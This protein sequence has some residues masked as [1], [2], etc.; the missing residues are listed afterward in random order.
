M[1]NPF[2]NLAKWQYHIHL[3]ID[4]LGIFLFVLGGFYITNYLG[5]GLMNWQGYFIL[6]TALYLGLLI[7][8]PIV[9]AV[10]YILPPPF[11]WRD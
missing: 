6:L 10:F 7:V 11:Q 2:I 1:G 8:D 4:V 3:I 9:H 5:Y